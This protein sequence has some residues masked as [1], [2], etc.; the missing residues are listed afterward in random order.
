MSSSIPILSAKEII[1]ILKKMGFV[2]VSQKGSHAKYKNMLTH[3][4]CIVPMHIQ[5]ARETLISILQQADIE[6]QDFLN[7]LK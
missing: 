4:I 3:R 7:Q 1:R 6:L 2:K 5:V